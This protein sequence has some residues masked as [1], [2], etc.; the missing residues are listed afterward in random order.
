MLKM[1]A[2]GNP[3]YTVFVLILFVVLLAY[4]F[5]K[6][7]SIVFFILP[8][9]LIFIG[10]PLLLLYVLNRVS[11]KPSG[12]RGN[13]TAAGGGFFTLDDDSSLLDD[14]D[15]PDSNN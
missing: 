3:W 13:G 8:V 11:P 7:D 6:G 15:S 10:L 5:A 12:E 9:L 2:P 4:G 1:R 14:R